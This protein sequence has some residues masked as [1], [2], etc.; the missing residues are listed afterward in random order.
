MCGKTKEPSGIRSY[1][2]VVVHVNPLCSDALLYWLRYLGRWDIQEKG[3]IYSGKYWAKHE[4]ITP[5]FI[6]LRQFK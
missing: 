2:P 4:Q 3:A 6:E 1:A 5:G